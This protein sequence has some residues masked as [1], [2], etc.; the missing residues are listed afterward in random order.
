[1]DATALQRAGGSSDSVGF[2]GVAAR[3]RA[4]TT[5]GASWD[6]LMATTKAKAIMA[7]IA[8]RHKMMTSSFTLPSSGSCNP[9][10][11]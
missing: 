11:S 2:R 3:G 10:R 6:V 8:G 1:M 4:L 7:T 9:H 5:D